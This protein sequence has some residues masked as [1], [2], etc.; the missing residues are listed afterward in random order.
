MGR[1]RQE[2]RIRRKSL[3]QQ[4]PMLFSFRVHGA[5]AW[6]PDWLGHCRNA[7]CLTTHTEPTHRRRAFWTGRVHYFVPCGQTLTF[8]A[9]I[10]R[11]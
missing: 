3:P 5:D 4:Q 1:L 2:G 10:S 9:L 6:Y 7:G 8:G 11:F